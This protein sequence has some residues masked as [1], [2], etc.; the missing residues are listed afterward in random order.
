MWLRE[1]AAR[2]SGAEIPDRHVG[3]LRG[4]SP[5]RGSERQ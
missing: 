1:S 3:R 4:I 2:R 5:S